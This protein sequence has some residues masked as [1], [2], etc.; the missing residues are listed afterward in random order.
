M[1]FPIPP[2]NRI[3]NY[4]NIF[5]WTLAKGHL[6]LHEYCWSPRDRVFKLLSLCKYHKVIFYLIMKFVHLALVVLIPQRN[7]RTFLAFHL[8]KGWIFYLLNRYLGDP[9]I[10]CG[11][12]YGMEI[13]QESVASVEFGYFL[14]CQ[15][16]TQTPLTCPLQIRWLCGFF[17]GLLISQP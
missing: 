17:V 1:P 5:V 12:L 16:C 15:S 11:A 7:K 9:L 6:K 3:L 2:Y 10:C 14:A 13:A 4:E 8:H